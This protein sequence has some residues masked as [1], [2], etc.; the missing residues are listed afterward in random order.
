MILLTGATGKCGSA[1]A[2][3]LAAR[4]ARLRALVRDASKAAPLAD[5]GIELIVGDATEPGV[6][7]RAMEGCEKA[8]LIM[9]NSEQQ[10]DLEQRFT[11][12]ARAAGIRH[13]VKLSSIEAVATAAIP[14]PQI[15]W[16]S[17]EYIRRSGVPW[18]MIKP[19]FFMQNLLANAPTI[20]SMHKFFLPLDDGRTGMCDTRDVGAVIAE[21]LSGTGHEGQSYQI[22]GPE[23]L[24]FHDVAD[25]FSEVLGTRIE[26]V[27]QPAD[28]YREMLAQFLTSEWHLNAV[29]ALFAQ[30][31]KGGL[32]E[33]STD[34][35]RIMGREPT[36]LRRFIED[37]KAAFVP[38]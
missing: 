16:A 32:N 5:A 29:C 6:I 20:K 25:R 37:H 4:G 2:K 30:I 24:S 10:L 19:N 35:R 14:I 38:D 8:L 33:V 34:F 28:S 7:E 36:S 3:E 22:T 9:P 1:A 15:H 11:D 12:V 21:A 13:L 18:T 31:A 23:L 17:E 26:Y 27:N